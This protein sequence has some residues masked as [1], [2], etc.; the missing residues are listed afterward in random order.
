MKFL[1]NMGDFNR[2]EYAHSTRRGAG[3]RGAEKAM[4]VAGREITPI[5]KKGMYIYKKVC[6]E[7]IPYSVCGANKGCGPDFYGRGL[8]T[9][10]KVSNKI[11]N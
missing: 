5:E 1:W 9:Y 2:C 3:G 7:L 11:L 6:K 4:G 8:V 10:Q